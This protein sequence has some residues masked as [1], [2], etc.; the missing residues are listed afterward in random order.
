MDIIIICKLPDY[1]QVETYEIEINREAPYCDWCKRDME[2]DCYVA[3]AHTEIW[4][5]PH[6]GDIEECYP[7][8]Y[9]SDFITMNEQE[10]QDY[11]GNERQEIKLRR[12]YGTAHPASIRDYWK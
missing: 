10:Y 12:R 7:G 8:D 9:G 2:Y 5:C 11:K 6:C 4:H 1:A 3:A